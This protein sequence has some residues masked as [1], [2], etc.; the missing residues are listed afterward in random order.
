MKRLAII[1]ASTGQIELC[2]K[3]KEMKNV[4]T[5]CFAWEKGN[6]CKNIVDHFIPIS[7]LEKDRIVDYCRFLGVDG[8]V[9]NASELTAVISNY[10]AEK[11]G[12]VCTPSHI[13]EQIQDKGFVR[14][15]TSDILGLTSVKSEVFSLSELN[16]VSDFPCVIKPIKGSGK[17]GVNFLNSK[18]NLNLY[19]SSKEDK[20]DKYLVEQYIEGREV[21]VESLSYKGKHHVIQITDKETSGPPHFVEL[22]H[23]QPSS[24]S[25]ELK[26]QIERVVPYILTAV[27]F[28]N[29]ASHIEMKIDKSQNLYLI[30]VNPRGGGDSISNRL[31]GLST[32]IDYVKEIINIALDDFVFVNPKNISFSGIYFICKQTERVLDYMK[33]NSFEKNKWIVDFQYDGK[34]LNV[35]SSNYNRNG[36]VLYVN[37]SSKIEL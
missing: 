8:V 2:K 17:K 31:V 19:L 25:F 16:S 5:F 15:L 34:E 4:E 12:L 26:A 32:N 33:N 24:L 27:G 3:A 36:F 9:S 21:S 14:S 11:L 7:I 13:I 20:F 22:A 28:E 6:V 37:K 1:G 35:A 23:H 30:E 18:E 10:V 29:G